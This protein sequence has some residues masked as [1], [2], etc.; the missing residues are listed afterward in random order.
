MFMRLTFTVALLAPLIAAGC[1]SKPMQTAE[2]TTRQGVN[3]AAHAPF[4]DFNLVRSKIPRVLLEAVSDPYA[5]PLPVTCEALSGELARLDDALGADFDAP[6]TQRST[7][8]RSASFAAGAGAKA[9]K[10]LTEGWIPMRNWV[11]YMTGAEQHSKDVQGAISA[12]Q[13]RRAY[14]K[15]LAQSEGCVD[16]GPAQPVYLFPAPP[17]TPASVAQN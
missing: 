4:E 17:P 1:A 8:D 14:L 12:G 11:R 16:L 10:D 3:E 13:A 7:M 5:R 2:R 6:K 9:M 15:G